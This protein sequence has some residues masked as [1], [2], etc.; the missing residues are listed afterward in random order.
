MSQAHIIGVTVSETIPDMTM[1]ML[2]VTANSRNRRPTMPPI[3]RM[4]MNTAISDTVIETMV[5]PI[6]REPSIAACI[7]RRER[8]EMPDDVLDD[9]D[10]VIDDE[11]DGDRQSHQGEVVEAVAEK[12]HR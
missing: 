12:I 6:S 4:G 7:S 8:R 11:A 3:S 10:G 9:D 2:T 1:A 5:K